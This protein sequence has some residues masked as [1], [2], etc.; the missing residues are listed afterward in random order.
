MSASDTFSSGQAFKRQKFRREYAQIE[1]AFW[2]R[3]VRV[4]HLKRT[5]LQELTIA[6]KAAKIIQARI[7]KTVRVCTR[8]R[9]KSC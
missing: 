3:R 5:V 4:K 9:R 8:F 2:W 6:R 1:V 7:D